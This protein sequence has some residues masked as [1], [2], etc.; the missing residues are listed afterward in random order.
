MKPV[1][2]SK[3]ASLDLD[4]LIHLLVTASSGGGKTWALLLLLERALAEGIHQV[5]LDWEGEFANLRE[6][7]DYVLVGKDGDLP[8]DVASAGLL[9]QR[10]LEQKFNLIVDL[11]EADVRDRHDFAQAFLHGFLR[12]PRDQWH[13]TLVVIDESHLLCPQKDKRGETSPAKAEVVNLAAMGRKRGFRLVLATQRLAKLDKDTAGECNAVLVGK[14]NLP[15]DRERAVEVLGVA[16][17]QRNAAEEQVRRLKAGHFFALGEA[18]DATDALLTGIE[19]PRTKPPP[20][21][22][23]ARKPPAPREAV[24]HAL[25]QLRDLPKRA[26]EE[27]A[28]IDE[29]RIEV[30]RL[31]R[32]LMAARADQPA[33]PLPEVVE[34]EVEVTIEKPVPFIPEEVLDEFHAVGHALCVRVEKL[35]AAYPV[36]DLREHI[37]REEREAPSTSPYHIKPTW[38]V[39]EV[40]GEVEPR[41]ASAPRSSGNVQERILNS[42]AELHTLGVHEVPRA[43]LATFA[44]YGH[45]NSKG[46][47]NGLGACNTAG[48]TETARG[49]GVKLTAQGRA[50]AKPARPP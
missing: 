46:F 34:R 7:G 40:P 10:C 19:E 29:L 30:N 33:F 16:K 31:E 49:G 6:R 47:T 32:E 25:E 4:R 5:I 2:I 13:D 23:G 1:S 42:L 9:A 45:V 35:R 38:T 18:F 11:S 37:R 21:G 20:K 44:G 24:L 36:Q 39:V 14:H 15:E 28:T 22:A 27:A 17:G 3:D 8:L 48:L 12:A 43:L 41:P 26:R 50:R